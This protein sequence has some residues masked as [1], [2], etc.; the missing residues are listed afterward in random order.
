MLLRVLL[1]DPLA[2]VVLPHAS[3]VNQFKRAIMVVAL[4]VALVAASHLARQSR[5]QSLQRQKH[6]Q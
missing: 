1:H 3:D 6:M 2:R 5:W 4:A